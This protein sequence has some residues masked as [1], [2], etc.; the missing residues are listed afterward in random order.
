[1]FFFHF[2]SIVS[3]TTVTKGY[4]DTSPTQISSK[5]ANSPKRTGSKNLRR[6]ISVKNEGLVHFIFLKQLISL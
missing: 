3:T 5:L 6:L 2:V 4:K 1:M